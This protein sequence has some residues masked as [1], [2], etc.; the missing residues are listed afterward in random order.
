MRTLLG[1]T[2]GLLLCSG[3][4]ALDKKADPIDAKKLVG[5]WKLKNDDKDGSLT[6]DF[7]KD[8]KLTITI[9]FKDKEDK[10]TG[11]YKVEGNTLTITEKVGGKDESEKST[12]LK[13]TDTEM[14]TRREK[15]KEDDTFVRVKDK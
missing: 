13:L 11:S 2:L 6:L 5:K 9:K 14:V 15:A 4:V 3:L 7:A 10:S 1:C 12:I 8:G